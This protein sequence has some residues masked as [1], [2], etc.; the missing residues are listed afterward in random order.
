VIDRTT[1][2]AQFR[3]YLGADR[4]EIT[5]ISPA[6]GNKWSPAYPVVGARIV[7][8]DSID[9]ASVQMAMLNGAQAPFFYD[10]RDGSVSLVLRDDNVEKKQEV[11]LWARDVTSGRRVEASWT[12]NPAPAPAGTQRKVADR[13]DHVAPGSPDRA[14]TGGSFE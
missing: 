9:P 4:L 8:P 13:V 14:L 1:T 12:F 6:P 5:D 10:P 2:F 3:K 7:D 11:L